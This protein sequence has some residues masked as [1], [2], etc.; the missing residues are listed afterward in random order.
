LSED[1]D[2]QMRLERGVS[3]LVRWAWAPLDWVPWMVYLGLTLPR[4]YEARHWSFVW[5]G[6][7]V[8]EWVALTTFAWLTWKRRQLMLVTS[9]IAGT[10]LFA[11]VWFDVISSWGNRDGWFTLL[12]AVF[13]EAPVSLVFFWVAYREIRRTL[14]VYDSLLGRADH[15]AGLLRVPA[16]TVAQRPASPEGACQ[17]QVQI[18]WC[19]RVTAINSSL[20][21][22]WTVSWSSRRKVVSSRGESREPE[23]PSRGP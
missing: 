20:V 10:L 4:R 14:T 21:D 8:I 23:V 11:D 7:D 2:N 9:I 17:P 18:R 19:D 15:S 22:G 1:V 3:L 5:I 16:L 6:F 13:I 12:L